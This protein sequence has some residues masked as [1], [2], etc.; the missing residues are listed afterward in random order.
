MIESLDRAGVKPLRPFLALCIACGTEQLVSM[1]EIPSCE[2]GA[3]RW[4]V[5]ACPHC[6]ALVKPRKRVRGRSE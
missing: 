6:R 2:C 1:D 4:G 5:A 3:R